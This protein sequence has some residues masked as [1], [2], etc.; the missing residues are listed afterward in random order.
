MFETYINSQFKQSQTNVS[1]SMSS[2]K[3]SDIS[4]ARLLRE[5]YK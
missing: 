3:K 4:D 2:I 1:I 5:I